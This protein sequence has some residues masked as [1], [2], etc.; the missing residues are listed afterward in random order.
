MGVKVEGLDKLTKNLNQ[1]SLKIQKQV[2]AELT[3]SAMEIEALAKSLVP[4]DEGRLK[5]SISADI[6]TPFRKEVTASAY[7]A[8]YVEFGT[9]G[10]VQVPS[11]LEQYA[12]QFKGQKRGSFKEFVD[13]LIGWVSRKKIAGTYSVKT[14]RRTGGK[15]LKDSQNKAMAWAIALKIMRE[16]IK[17]Q[18]F[19]FRAFNAIQPKIID[20]IKKVIGSK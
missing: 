10:K 13:S 20:R 19:F 6:N 3:A 14:R 18:P 16:G 8:P 11:G 4:I 12:A 1:Y 2:D 5:Q 7:Y 9:K 15:A 17:P